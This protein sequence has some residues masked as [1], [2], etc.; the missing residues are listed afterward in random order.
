MR[1]LAIDDSEDI[2]DF[3]QLL[4]EGAGYEV[5]VAADGRAGLDAVRAFR[6]DL[7]VTDISMPV[8]SGLEF[9]VQLRSQ[10]A[11]PLPPVIVCSG[12]DVTADE[13]LRLGALRFTA[14]PTDP[15]VLLKIVEDV[16]HHQP[17][18]ESALARER[19]FV[20]AARARATAAAARLMASVDLRHPDLTRVLTRFVQG[21]ADYFGDV[22]AGI[23]IV[24]PGG[25]VYV[26]AVSRD[27]P[28]AVGTTLSGNLLYSA[29]VLTAGASLVI[30]DWAA[31][32]STVADPRAVAFDLRFLVSVPLL[33]DDVPVGSLSLA[34]HKPHPFD[35]ED[36]LILEQIARDASA[37]LWVGPP[38]GKNL[39]FVSP[40]VFDRM[41][42]AEL[43]LLH[44]QRGS[45]ELLLVELEP[46]ADGELA[47]EL[48]ARGG[49]RMALCRRNGGRLA[50][51][52]RDPDARVAQRAIAATL[53]VLSERDRV[54]A[55][56]WVS[57]VDHG[58]PLVPRP[59]LLQLACAA[60]DES[61][62]KR[63]GQPERI[64]IAGE[65]AALPSP[66]A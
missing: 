62:L 4:F 64:V 21:V 65:P 30:C 50:I 7:V 20:Q 31:F 28:V 6:P 36:L 51:L 59:V 39:G 52:K 54:R 19:T 9:L 58:L 3:F 26:T 15:A 35:A 47:L 34:D 56:S 29:G 12:F 48:V 27:C 66:S 45:I 42:G 24:T 44:R 53:A 10:L 17:A 16:L 25:D 57:L 61:I 38:I 23:T 32:A 2:R 33:F 46:A 11:P 13:A 55:A 40:A 1:I 22:S 60:L 18:D 8:M 49:A 14:K 43:S 41:L 37:E 63:T 5:R